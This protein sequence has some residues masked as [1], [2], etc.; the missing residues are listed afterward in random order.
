MEWFEAWFNSKDYLKVYRHRDEEEAANLAGLILDNIK[1]KSGKKVLDM[2]TG[3]GRHAI[4]F[5]KEGFE[6]TAVDLSKYLLSVAKKKAN[7]NNL[8][9]HFVHSDIRQFEV[10]TKFNLILNLFTSIGYFEN[11][12][13]NYSVLEKAYNLLEDDGY[14]VLDY[15]NKYLVE[16]NLIPSTVDELDGKTISQKRFIKGNRIIKEI[17]IDNGEQVNKY[18]ESVRM[19][20]DSELIHILK[21]IG[22]KVLKTFGNFNGD[23][24]KLES[25]PRIII[26]AGK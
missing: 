6:V 20:S 3:S 17:S 2:A 16:K 7:K 25:S 10:N 5:A 1:I 9:I 14:F 4:Y 21:K 22:F 8:N 26:I 18:I 12:E 24:F 19:F 15:L 23:P 11:D 13:E